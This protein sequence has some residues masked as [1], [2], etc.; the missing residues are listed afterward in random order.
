MLVTAHLIARSACCPECGRR[1]ERVHGYYGR[2]PADLPVCDRAVR[3]CL[4]VRRF[5]CEYEPCLRKTFAGRLPNLVAPHARR[6]G[7]LAGTQAHVGLVT[8][9]EPGARLLGALRMPASADTV[10]RLLHHHPVPDVA[11]PRVLGVDDWA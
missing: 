11:T 1:S 2:Y 3:L 9:A 5:R 6:T 8:G 10:L 7:R 4:R